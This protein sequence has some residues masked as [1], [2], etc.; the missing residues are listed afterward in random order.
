VLDELL[1]R[2][3]LTN[4]A[5]HRPCALMLVNQK[6]TSSPSRMLIAGWNLVGKP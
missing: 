4:K 6:L 5:F 2:D 3:S 1:I